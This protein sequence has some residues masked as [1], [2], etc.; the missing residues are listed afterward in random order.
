[1]V[2]LR[3]GQQW[4]IPSPTPVR[5]NLHALIIS[6]DHAI[7]GQGVNPHVV[8]IPPSLTAKGDPAIK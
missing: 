6:N 2:H 3:D 1:M 5:R 7:R 4:P 8:V